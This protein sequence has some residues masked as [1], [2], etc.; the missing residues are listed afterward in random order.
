MPETKPRP[1]Y[2]DEWLATS[3]GEFWGVTGDFEELLQQIERIH[4]SDVD[5]GSARDIDVF[6]PGTSPDW[7]HWLAAA[8]PETYQQEIE[9]DDKPTGDG[10]ETMEDFL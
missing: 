1:L 3:T 4:H 9:I 7:M 2:H 5:D 10:L 8:D 6:E